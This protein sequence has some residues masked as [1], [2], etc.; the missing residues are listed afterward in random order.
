MVA[1]S[2]QPVLTGAAH[3]PN[4][5][6]KVQFAC[7]GLRDHAVEVATWAAAEMGWR[8]CRDDSVT[9]RIAPDPWP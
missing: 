1:V 3:T 6:G 5:P 9:S 7:F 8:L 4:G 2:F